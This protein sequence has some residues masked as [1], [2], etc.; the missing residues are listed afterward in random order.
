MSCKALLICRSCAV[1]LLDG[2]SKQ[3]E[4]YSG[5]N[6]RK[7]FLLNIMLSKSSLPIALFKFLIRFL[8][9]CTNAFSI[10]I[11]RRIALWVCSLK[12]YSPVEVSWKRSELDEARCQGKTK[13]IS[14]FPVQFSS[15]KG[16]AGRSRSHYS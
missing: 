3:L 10:H 6:R 1:C 7:T 4:K 8:Q 13:E 12:C 2:P 15:D 16:F 14:C 5:E 11:N 9:H